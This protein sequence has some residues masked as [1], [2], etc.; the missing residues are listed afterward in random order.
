MNQNSFLDETM[1]PREGFIYLILNINLWK[2]AV[3]QK[4]GGES[5][6]LVL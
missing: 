3:L 5:K 2:C 1:N 6:E 4:M